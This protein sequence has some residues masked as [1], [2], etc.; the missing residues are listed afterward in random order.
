MNLR[1][2]DK[3]QPTSPRA[4]QTFRNKPLVVDKVTKLTFVIIEPTETNQDQQQ[5]D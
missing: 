2:G 1:P 5:I 4:V 3:H